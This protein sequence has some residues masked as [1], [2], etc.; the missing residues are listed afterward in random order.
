MIKKTPKRYAVSDIF[1]FI[2]S[3]FYLEIYFQADRMIKL[4]Y[5]LLSPFEII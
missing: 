3:W 2:K 5:Y 4:L 1:E